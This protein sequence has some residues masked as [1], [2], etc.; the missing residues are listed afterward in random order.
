MVRSTVAGVAET[1]GYA[2]AQAFAGVAET[3][4]YA[5]ARSTDAGVA[6]TGGICNGAKPAWLV[7]R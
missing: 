4:G 6:E 1:G 3:G 7:Y 2:N 5:M